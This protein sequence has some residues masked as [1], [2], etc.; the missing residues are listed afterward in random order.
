VGVEISAVAP[1]ISA[2]LAPGTGLR[3]PKEDAVFKEMDK[4]ARLRGFVLGTEPHRRHDIDQGDIPLFQEEYLEA[5][6][7]DERPD[8][9]LRLKEAVAIREASEQGK[10]EKNRGFRAE[11]PGRAS[12]LSYPHGRS[13]SQPSILYQKRPYWIAGRIGAGKAAVLECFPR[14]GHEEPS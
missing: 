9:L 11:P 12:I 2:D 8:R 1:D 7:E 5:V 4:A 14:G 3:P 6:V 13:H 10:D